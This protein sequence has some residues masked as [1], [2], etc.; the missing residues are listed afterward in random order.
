MRAGRRILPPLLAL[1]LLLAAWSASAQDKPD[2]LVL[3][4]QGDYRGAIEV[5]VEELEA[6]PYNGDSFAVMGW[7]LLRLGEF[8]EALKQSLIGL[9][10]LPEDARIIET[11]GEAS[12][13]L[14][15]VEDALRYLEEY[16]NLSPQGSRIERV[17]AIMGEC[18]IQLKEYNN[19]DIALSMAL[20]LK[21][22]DD[23]WWAR[24]GYAREMAKD[25]RW[26]LEA[27]SNSLRLNPA[28]QDAQRGR[29]RVEELARAP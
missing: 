10:R 17:Y 6:M 11:A 8:E 4:N 14:G 22:N 3:F 27:Y 18:F 1:A 7:S 15:K 9:Q 13:N 21:E 24:L 29:R 16:A 12:Y 23:T 28:N 2:A 5:C 20:H 19:A 26:S 25:Y